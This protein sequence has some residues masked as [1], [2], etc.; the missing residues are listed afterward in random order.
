MLHICCNPLAAAVSR[1]YCCWWKTCDDGHDAWTRRV[2][3]GVIEWT[4]SAGGAHKRSTTT[5]NVME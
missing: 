1:T 4:R 3:E 2:S 5:S